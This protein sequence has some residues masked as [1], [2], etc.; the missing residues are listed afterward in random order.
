MGE[1]EFVSL[2][3]TSDRTIIVGKAENG[4]RIYN[5]QSLVMTMTSPVW[6]AMFNPGRFLEGNPD[7]PVEFPDDDPDALLILLR[8]IHFQNS[9]VPK[10]LPSFDSLV[11]IAELCDKYDTVNVVRPHL[12]SWM[13]PWIAF[14]L[15]PGYERW[16]FIAWTFGC[17]KIFDALAASL[18]LDTEIHDND[19]IRR[20]QNLVSSSGIL[21]DGATPLESWISCGPAPP[22][23]V[24]KPS[25]FNYSFQIKF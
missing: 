20:S 17:P 25:I 16:L 2:S 13:R 3:D 9:L 7:V 10:E 15:E 8:I 19:N 5:V 12:E 21:Q 24:G 4:Q 11:K 22:E 18:I 14:C 1:R 6:K 23:I